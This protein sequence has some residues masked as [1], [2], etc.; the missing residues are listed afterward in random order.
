M[1]FA[2]TTAKAHPA[3]GIVV[4]RAGNIYFSDLETVWKLDLQGKLS[5]FR[6]SVRGRHVH[7]LAIDQQDNIYGADVSYES[8]KWISD[9]WSMTPEGKFTYLLSPT[10]DPPRGM[11]IWRDR[12]GNMYLVDQNN[13]L[14]QRTLLLRRA[15]DGTVITFA[16][17]AYGHEDGK[18]TAAKFSSVGGMAFGPDD[19]LYL[20]DGSSVRKVTMDG[21]VTTVA[22]DLTVRTPEDKPTLFGGSYGSLAG[23]AVNFEGNIYVADAGNRRLLKVSHDGKVDVALRTE[24]PYFPNGVAAFGRDLFV[25]EVGFTLPNISIG[26]RI[27][28]ITSDGK[29]EIL[30][31][32]GSEGAVGGFKASLAQNVG[33][34]AE[35]AMQFLFE[36]STYAVVTLAVAVVSLIVLIRQR[37]RRQRS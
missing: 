16:G 37:Q 12:A 2:P 11:S 23:L 26:P 19:S 10:N 1:L 36:R 33:V 31:T 14:K 8:Q 35:S 7:E 6:Q 18:G 25:L 15:P 24:P 9:V 29:S 28:K 27:R 3:S 22:R 30:A 21:N 13:H 17:G 34:N 5:V 32:V 4:D 20:T